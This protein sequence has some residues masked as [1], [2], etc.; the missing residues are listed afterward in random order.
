MALNDSGTITT[1]GTA[2][3]LFLGEVPTTRGFAVYNPDSSEYLF[4]D[5]GSPAVINGGIP[6]PPLGGYETPANYSPPDSSNGVSIIG[7]TTG[8]KFKAR[9][10]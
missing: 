5:D 9:L 4:V 1:G 8:H 10:W 3:S 2:Q 7:A 6:V